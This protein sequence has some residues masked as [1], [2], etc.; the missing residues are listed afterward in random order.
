MPRPMWCRVALLMLMVGLPVRA[1]VGAQAPA[2]LTRHEGKYYV[3]YT[4]LS[5]DAVR[6]ADLRMS[7]MAEEYSARTKAFSGVIRDKLPCYL[8]S[9]EKDY[10]D[11]GGVAGTA[12][13]FDRSRGLLM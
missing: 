13:L 6:E 11:F 9:R 10:L 12:G 4:D 7:R 5:A 8:F 1:G 3:I 2:G